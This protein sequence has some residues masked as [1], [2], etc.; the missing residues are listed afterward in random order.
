MMA[1]DRFESARD[2]YDKFFH[3]FQPVTYQETW[4]NLDKII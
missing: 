2:N 3:Q 4:K 1:Y